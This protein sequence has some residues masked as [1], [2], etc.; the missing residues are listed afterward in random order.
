M[1]YKNVF[2]FLQII[3]YTLNIYLKIIVYRE[4]IEI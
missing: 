4:V 2:Q 1:I 3:E